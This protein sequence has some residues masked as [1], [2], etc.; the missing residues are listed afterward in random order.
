MRSSSACLAQYATWP[1]IQGMEEITQVKIECFAPHAAMAP[2]T[3]ALGQAGFGT[4][5]AYDHCFSITSVAGSW[6]PLPGSQPRSG[7]IGRISHGTE[8]K[9]EFNCPIEQA[10]KA[11][12]LILSVHPYEEPLLNVV[13]LFNGRFGAT[14]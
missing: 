1:I 5:G 12:A 10:E 14:S 4:I 7:E 2:I 9:L 6:R 3:R 8:A 11:V 13:P